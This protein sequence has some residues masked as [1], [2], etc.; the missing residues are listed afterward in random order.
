MKVLDPG[1]RYELIHLDGNDHEILTFVKREGNDYPGNIGHYPG[2]NMQ[3]V[4]RVLIDRLRYVN[5]QIHDNR[6]LLA[7]E[8]LQDAIYLLEERAAAR[9]HRLVTFEVEGIELL[10]TCPKCGHIG[11]TESEDD[12]NE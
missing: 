6:N 12:L 2:T 7:I 3:E 1:H 5:N 8:H 9:H 4:L 10:P 11:C